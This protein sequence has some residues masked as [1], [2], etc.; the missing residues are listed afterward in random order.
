MSRAT[1][2]RTASGVD[3]DGV[4][5]RIRSDRNRPDSTSTTAALMPLPPT[6]MPIAIRLLAMSG[7]SSVIDASRTP[8]RSS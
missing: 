5:T 3:G 4:A 1:E 6:S 2:A 7:V 8:L